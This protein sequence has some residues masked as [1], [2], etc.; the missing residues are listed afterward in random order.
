M[1]TIQDIQKLIKVEYGIDAIIESD[2]IVYDRLRIKKAKP[3]KLP[4]GKSLED[5][6]EVQ[7]TGHSV[8]FFRTEELEKSLDSTG[9]LLY[10]IIPPSR[11]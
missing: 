3:T 8:D 6:W 7:R 10:Y 4:V 5:L 11:N 1:K 9:S 2:Y